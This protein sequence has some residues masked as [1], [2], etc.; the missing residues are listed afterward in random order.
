MDIQNS[1]KKYHTDGKYI[2]SCQYHVIFC[3]KYRRK[4]LTNG[5]DE[6]LK[7]LIIEKQDEYGYIIYDMEVMPDHI[8]LILDVNPKIGIYKIVQQIKGYTSYSLR[9]EFPS[10]KSRIP[11]LWTRSKFI[12]SVGC[13]SLEVVKKYIEEQKTR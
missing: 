13:V 10:L 7:E 2:Y 6:R 9:K 3:P 12:A 11:T 4:V 5:I 8:H 1:S